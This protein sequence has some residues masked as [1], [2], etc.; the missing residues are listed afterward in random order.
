MSPDPSKPG[1]SGG[2]ALPPG[3]GYVPGI[4]TAVPV[5]WSLMAPAS[6]DFDDSRP[7]DSQPA[8]PMAGAPQSSATTGPGDTWF[9]FERVTTTRKTEL[10][11][12]VFD[13]VAGKYDLMNDLM[14]G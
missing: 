13:S 6:P 4:S 9:G 10:V 7:S 2:L 5:K 11:R 1:R 12:G 8:E 14:S 3:P